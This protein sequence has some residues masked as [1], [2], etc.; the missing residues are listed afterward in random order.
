[1]TTLRSPRVAALAAVASWLVLASWSR[2]G[3][4]TAGFAGRLLL[5]IALVC[6]AGVGLRRIGLEWPFALS[7]QLLT[8]LLVLQAQL[9]TSWLPTTESTRHALLALVHAL[10]SASQNPSPVARGLPSIVPLLLAGG[11]AVH[12]VVDLVAVSLGRVLPASLPLLA[13][14]VLPVSVLGTASGALPFLLAA[15]AWV[16][17]IATHEQVERGRW[18]HVAAHG[19]S[20]TFRSLRQ[21]V[22]VGG[23]ALVLATLL[24]GVLPHREP[25]RLDGDG[26]SGTVRVADPVADLRRN[27]TRGTDIDLMRVTLGGD[28]APPSYVRLT[29]LDEFDGKAWRAGPRSWPPDN[30]VDGTFPAAPA[31]G[32]PGRRVPWHVTISPA[33]A[34]DW[35][36]LPTWTV[37]VV[38]G[39]SWRYDSNQLDVHRA[40]TP[41]TTAGLHYIVDEYR[42]RIDAARLASTPPDPTRPAADTAL[43]SARPAW[44]RTLARKITAGARTNYQR[45]VDL[46]EW[47]Q[48]D[49]TYST[50]TAAG[51]GFAALGDFL[52]HSRSGYCEQFA[53]SMA[54]LARE[55]DMPARVSVGFLRP[56]HVTGLTYEFSAHDL[57]A[58]PEIWFRGVGWVGF[59]PTPTS[60]TGTLP[61]WSRPRTQPSPS[62]SATSTATP[63]AAP[64]PGNKLPD[65]GPVSTRSHD[66]G[67]PLP[68]VLGTGLV[69]VAGL[70]ATPWFVR[71]RQRARRL[72][73]PD[74]EAWWAELHATATDLGLAWPAGRSP[75]ATAHAIAPH[76]GAGQQTAAH[77]ALDRVVTTL[78]L[79]RYASAGTGTAT[80]DDVATC[81][82]ALRSA[83]ERRVARRATWWPRSVLG[84]QRGDGRLRKA[85]SA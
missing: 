20:A 83:S 44:V 54:L 9:G 34:S 11:V 63:S 60:H 12:L 17:L 33:F 32:L 52:N 49:F 68:L 7:G 40:G 43:P 22:V 3:E 35:L 8:A 21:L 37:K 64:R 23:A 10:D 80:S 53:A 16:A 15:A 41:G 45:A 46:Q 13:A 29:V 70:A 55:L 79:R 18:G 14:W 31:L 71:R 25:Y 61:A 81:S 42:P 50:D 27:L 2:L 28:A 5:A 1:M 38:T 62:T 82:D 58:W 69:L 85:D 78:E 26:P 74:V 65:E 76:L 59:E 48:H 72:G 84:G 66:G 73:S 4:D 39:D 6:A 47:F 24:P 77:E 51:S 57:H 19:R 36:P 56:R 75:R 67:V 30:G